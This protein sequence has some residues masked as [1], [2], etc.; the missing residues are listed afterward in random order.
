MR[1]E[2]NFTFFCIISSLCFLLLETWLREKLSQ[3]IGNDK[4]L[5]LLLLVW[6]KNGNGLLLPAPDFE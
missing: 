1:K 5:L 6:H 2:K 3:D 4:H